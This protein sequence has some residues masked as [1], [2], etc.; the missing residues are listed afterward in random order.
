MQT[1]TDILEQVKQLARSAGEFILKEAD[2]FKVSDIQTKGLNDLVSHV[3]LNSERML[4]EGLRNIV[5]EAGFITEEGTVK[6]NHE[7]NFTWVIDPLDG[8][9]NFVHGFPPY[10]IS[11]ALCKGEDIEIG[12]VYVITSDEM[13]YAISGSG[14]WLNN[15]QISVSETSKIKDALVGTGFPFRDYDLLDSYLNT[16]RFFIENTQGVRRAG[17]AAVD[18]AY[19]A[20]GRLDSF[21]E[22]NL[23]PWDVSAGILIIREAGGV[24]TDFSGKESN[25]TGSEIIASNL[26]VYS[27]FFNS[28]I[29]TFKQRQ[30]R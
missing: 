9:T 7:S 14:A 30:I 17:S 4:V 26:R 29:K 13:F 8:T 12:L 6:T 2:K 28:V 23:N 15:K 3:D 5:P 22:Y 21:F 20:C 27:D 16:L 11:I 19:V 10:S 18:L 25:L 1:Y 24:V